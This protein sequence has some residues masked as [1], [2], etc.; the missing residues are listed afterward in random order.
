MAA[1]RDTAR[2]ADDGS[3]RERLVDAAVAVLAEEGPAEMKV[4]RISDRAGSSTITVYH[5]FGN[6]GGLLDAVVARGYATLKGTLEDAAASNDDPGV[7]LFAMALGTRGFAQ[8]NPHL[9]DLMF[10]LSPRGTH[11][12]FAPTVPQQHFRDAYAVLVGSCHR[13][14]TAGRVDIDDPEQIAAQLWSMVHGFVSLEAAGHFADHNDAVADVLAPMAVAQLVGI[15]DD[16][17]RATRGALDAY[18]TWTAT[19]V[20]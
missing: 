12:A 7:Q 9:Y 19:A 5:H 8:R 11:R 18:A 6:V 13:L 17:A 4:R 2:T 1:R 20:E 16:R 14:V 10:G 15:G 3:T